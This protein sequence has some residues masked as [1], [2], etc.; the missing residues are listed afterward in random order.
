MKKTVIILSALLFIMQGCTNAQNNNDKNK[1]KAKVI[2]YYFH[3]THRCPGC[4]ASEDVAFKSTKELYPEQVKQGV[5]KCE[6][7]NFEEKD[8]KALAEKYQ[9]A[10]S[11]LLIVKQFNGKEEKTDLTSDAFSYARSSPEKLKELI[12]TTVDKMLK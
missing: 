8:N 2:V 1:E 5:I 11:T 3:G 7:V 4:L 12:K 6:S 9:V 10:W